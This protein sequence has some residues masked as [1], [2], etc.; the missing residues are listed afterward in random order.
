MSMHKSS[1]VMGTLAKK[2]IDWMKVLDEELA[3][4]INDM[5][6]RCDRQQR[7]NERQRSKNGKCQAEEAEKCQKE[8]EE[9]HQKEAEV[10]KKQK[11]EERKQG[12]LGIKRRLACGS[13]MKA[14]KRCKWPEVEMTWGEL[15]QAVSSHMDVANGHL[16]WIASTAQSNSRKVQWHHLLMEGLVGQQQVLLSKLVKMA[17]VAGSGGAREVTKGQEELKEPQETQGE[18][19]GCQE[20]E[21]QGV[22]GGALED[23]PEDVLGEELENGTGAEDGA[24]E[25][26]QRKYKGKGKEKAL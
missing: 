24:G 13:C 21:T 22:P 8:E 16:E 11:D 15:I 5:D 14:K 10:E 25:E 6:L 3:T 18:G 19:S 23:A 17:G 26:A 12:A 4:D 1:M 20:G 7:C 9:R 2:S